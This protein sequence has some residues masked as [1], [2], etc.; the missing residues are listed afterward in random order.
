MQMPVWMVCVSEKTVCVGSLGRGLSRAS[1]SSVARD[2]HGDV[3]DVTRLRSFG[4]CCLNGS[5]SDDD[6][7]LRGVCGGVIGKVAASV[8]AT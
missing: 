7:S 5:E 4:P 2:D 8:I 3:R 1:G 6:S